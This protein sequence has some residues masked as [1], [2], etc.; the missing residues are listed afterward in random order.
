MNQDKISLRRATSDDAPVVALLGWVAFAETF[1]HL[2]EPENLET[3]LHGTY[4]VQKIRSSIPKSYNTYWL[5][6]WKD[7]PGG[8]VKIKA[9]FPPP[10]DIPPTD[11]PWQLQKIY[12]QQQFL[13]KKLGQALFH[14]A[15]AHAWQQGATLL[16]LLVQEDNA[17]AIRFYEKNGWVK[18]KYLPFDLV[19]QRFYFFLMTIHKSE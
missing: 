16:W 17:R 11:A 10:G 9:N 12:V 13:D 19:N 2:F 6:Y 18:A 3:Y 1:G 4:S 8:F 14:N 7:V 5:A 15:V